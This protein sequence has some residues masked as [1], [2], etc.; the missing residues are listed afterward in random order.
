MIET[1]N[2]FKG[3]QLIYVGWWTLELAA[4]IAMMI[5][6]YHT[7]DGYMCH[8]L[9]T[10]IVDRYGVRITVFKQPCMLYHVEMWLHLVTA[11]VS[12]MRLKTEA[13]QWV[14]TFTDVAETLI[15]IV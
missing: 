6:I 15:F 7:T 4:F 5:T 12:F 10:I 1:L 13:A 3:Y 8:E 11:I 2:M 14:L 9:D